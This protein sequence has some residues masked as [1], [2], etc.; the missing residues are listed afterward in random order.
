M[1]ASEGTAFQPV[2][3]P[4]AETRI[5]RTLVHELLLEQHPD[6]AELPLTRVAEGWDN[7]TY[8]LGERFAVRLPRIAAGAAL[9]VNEQRW[10]P[11][12]AEVLPVPV[13]TPVRLGRAGRGFPWAW[14]VV[15]WADGVSADR[16]AM[17]ADQAE[18]FGEFLAALHSRAPLDA[19]RNTWRGIP[20]REISAKTI[21]RIEN[22]ATVDGALPVPVQDL[23]GLWD[24]AVTAAA[25]PGE[26]WVHG[27]L[28]PK[29]IV[30][31]DGKL[32]SVIDWGDMTVGDPANDLAAAW[33]LFAPAAHP[34][35]WRAYGQ[36]DEPTM[37][38][39]MGW[40]LF[41]GLTLVE[42]GLAGDAAFGRIGAA[43]LRRLFQP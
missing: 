12:L 37:A 4:P 3:I 33:M 30:V 26:T 25:D 19:P 32:A 23:L 16:A 10:L 38:R 36:I 2:G 7:V 17:D 5:D 15:P 27:D 11:R 6:L 41:F 29:N 35:I 1:T 40:A 21:T 42:V 34:T 20:L 8:R 14:S 9:L 31:L 43:T 28:H 22:L 13:P 18:R 24:R 39:A